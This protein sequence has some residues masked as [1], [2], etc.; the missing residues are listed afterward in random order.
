MYRPLNLTHHIPT[1][2]EPGAFGA[3][4]KHDIHTGIDLYCSDNEPV[5]AVEDGTVVAIEDFTG[6][7]AG[8]PW[9]NTT[10]AILVEGASGVICY[11]EI[12][13]FE[14]IGVWETEYGEV[15]GEEPIKVGDRVNAG[16]TLGFVRR[17][18]K[19]DKGVTPTSM[20]HFELYK[21]GTTGSVWWHHGEPQPEALLDPTE[22]LKK[23]Y[24]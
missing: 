6:P 15:E 23:I 1:I 17:V 4:R 11:G 21:P 16:D 9:W 20:L 19:K 10:Q 12:T 18:L 8:S 24:A 5:F 13:I 14:S 2:G 7:G 22:L 3:I